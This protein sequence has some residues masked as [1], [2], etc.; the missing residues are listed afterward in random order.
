MWLT[1]SMSTMFAVS[2]AECLCMC[3]SACVAIYLLFIIIY[4]NGT[5]GFGL[6]K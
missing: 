3:V 1:L 4:Q 5:E 2:V 6:K